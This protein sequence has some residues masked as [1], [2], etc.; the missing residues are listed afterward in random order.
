MSHVLSDN[1]PFH[2]LPGKKRRPSTVEASDLLP[3][4]LA[5]G[6]KV[7]PLEVE[8]DM[9]RGDGQT[10]KVEVEEEEEEE[11]RDGDSGSQNDGHNIKKNVEGFH[12]WE[13]RKEMQDAYNALINAAG[14]A[15]KYKLAESLFSEVLNLGLPFPLK[16]LL[17]TAAI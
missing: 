6:N 2:L 13:V 7:S 10:S 9:P 14:Q 15:G 1:R 8:M 17:I 11:E 5:V 3:V 4:S 16:D 12:H